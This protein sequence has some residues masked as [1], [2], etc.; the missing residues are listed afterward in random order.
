MADLSQF[1]EA[2]A[3]GEPG[4]ERELDAVELAAAHGLDEHPVPGARR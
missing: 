1:K 2:A 3:G 4:R